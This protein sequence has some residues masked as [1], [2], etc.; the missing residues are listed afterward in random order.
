MIDL[1]GMPAQIGG[2][3]FSLGWNLGQGVLQKDDF[4]IIS[5]DECQTLYQTAL[6]EK[7]ICATGKEN[8]VVK[9]S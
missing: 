3:A 9:S 4:A 1:M 5:D 6:S 2:V 8:C 7:I